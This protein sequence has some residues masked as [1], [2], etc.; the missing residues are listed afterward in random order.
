MIME[1]L[2]PNL[3]VLH[4][5][6]GRKFSEMTVALIAIE[7][8]KKLE[9]VHSKGFI[10]R[11]IK[12]ENLVIGPCSGKKE[13]QLYLIDFGLAKRFI[14]PRNG[15]HIS[16]KSTKGIIGTLDYLSYRATK[17]IEQ[18]RRDDLESMGFMLANFLDN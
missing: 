1:S 13:K 11:D 17:G 10:H 5:F 2:G 4:E 15:S 9:Y 18:S 14:D 8:L 16:L 3:D 6:C 12:P 7:L